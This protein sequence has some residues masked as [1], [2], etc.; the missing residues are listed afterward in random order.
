[1]DCDERTAA[2]LDAE[3]YGHTVVFSTDYPHEDAKFPYAVKTLLEQG[4]A[5]NFT[6][7]VLWDNARRLYGMG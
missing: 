2:H 3:G 5:E 4:F 1:M 7:R 6:R